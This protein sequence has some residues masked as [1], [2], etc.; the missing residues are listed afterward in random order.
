MKV[1]IYAL[2]GGLGHITRA[3]KLSIFLQ[4]LFANPQILVFASKQP[5]PKF[6][7]N[8]NL[9]W[10]APEN[11]GVIVD[12]LKTVIE[13]YKPDVWITDVFANGLFNELPFVLNNHK[14]LKIITVR[15]LKM[16]C[17]KI[18]SEVE[19][20]E[21][22]QIEWLPDYMNNYLKNLAL[23]NV[24]IRLEPLQNKNQILK[25]K[26]WILHTGS[27]KEIEKIQTFHPDFEYVKPNLF[28][29]LPIFEQCEIVTAAGCNII[30]DLLYLTK[31]HYIYPQNRKFD[32]QWVRLAN[33][34]YLKQWYLN[35][36]FF[37]GE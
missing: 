27:K 29:P 8:L 18:Y 22:W 32:D 4:R 13:T 12:C 21:S 28:F 2:G 5:I 37:F 35:V 30:H 23:K 1:F 25:H 16:E 24:P 3:Y 10:I 11:I 20:D 15:I 31:N 19:Y 17:T 34:Q 36:P 26:K 6:L 14:F 9:L 7:R 33:Y